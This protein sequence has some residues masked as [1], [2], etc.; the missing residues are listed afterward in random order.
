MISS[1][2]VILI[3]SGS[4]SRPPSPLSWTRTK[5]GTTW[6]H[7]IPYALLRDVWNLLAD[8][9]VRRDEQDVRLATR[10]YLIL[11]GLTRIA[12]DEAIERMR[13]LHPTRKPSGS[14]Q[15]RP[16]DE[17]DATTLRAR[18]VWQPWN[19]VEGESNRCDEP[20][21]YAIDWFRTGLPDDE[22]NRLKLVE[23]FEP[24]LRGYATSGPEPDSQHHQRLRRCAE[25]FYLLA[26]F[27][28]PIPYR[29]EMWVRVGGQWRKAR[30]GENG[31]A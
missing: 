18:V 25:D 19:L 1:S 27:K 6:H 3:G 17:G 14:R 29:P 10:A 4:D 20:G 31:I 12:A 8:R 30:R 16:Y 24:A 26:L 13:A 15:A 11:A 22:V 21:R 7:V 2:S 5:P 9:C 28:A 23:K